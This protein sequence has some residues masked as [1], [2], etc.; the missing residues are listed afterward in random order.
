[1]NLATILVLSAVILVAAAA[2]A[3]MVH[4]KKKTGTSACEGCALRDFCRK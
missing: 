1:M 4:R 2:V 3:F